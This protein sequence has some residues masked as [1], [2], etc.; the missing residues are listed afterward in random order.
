[1]R[2][3]APSSSQ[4]RECLRW[5]QVLLPGLLGAYLNC[6]VYGFAYARTGQEFQ[7]PLVHWLRDPSLYPNDPIRESFRRFPIGY[8]TVVAHFS[9]WFTIEEILFVLFLLTKV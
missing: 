6:V 2:A 4:D 3:H 5:T 7:L 8:W 1:M 9:R